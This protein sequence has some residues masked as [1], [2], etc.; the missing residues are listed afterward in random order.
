MPRSRRLIYRQRRA[1]K[2][3]CY[4]FLMPFFAAEPA[5][6]HVQNSSGK[7]VD[8]CVMSDDEDET[9]RIEKLLLDKGNNRPARIAIQRSGGL[10]HDENVRLAN[11]RPRNG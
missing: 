7:L 1:Q 9:I 11:H 4:S 6:L 8:S 10:I 5:V 2:A 3:T